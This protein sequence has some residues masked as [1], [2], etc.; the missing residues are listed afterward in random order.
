MA[1]VKAV[2]KI[3]IRYFGVIEFVDLD[4]MNCI[5]GIVYI[6]NNTYKEHPEIILAE[7]LKGIGALPTPTPA[8]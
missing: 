3:F 1:M 7:W 2:A 4:L 6:K 5:L 8:L